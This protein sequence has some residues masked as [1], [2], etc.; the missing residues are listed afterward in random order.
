MVNAFTPKSYCEDAT[1]AGGGDVPEDFIFIFFIIIVL[2]FNLPT[3]GK[4]KKKS[5]IKLPHFHVSDTCVAI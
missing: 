4:K 3:D 2:F 1:P 5:L